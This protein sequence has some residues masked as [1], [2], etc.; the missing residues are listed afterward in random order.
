M[1]DAKASL[2]LLYLCF[3]RSIENC[4][5]NVQ[6]MSSRKYDIADRVI[7]DDEDYYL[8]KCLNSGQR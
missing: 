2:L 4:R 1:T 6:N 5:F 7:A 8:I 3:S